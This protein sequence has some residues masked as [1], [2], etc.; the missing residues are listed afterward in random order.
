[1]RG[2]S[3]WSSS[4]YTS[5]CRYSRQVL[6][7]PAPQESLKI[8]GYVFAYTQQKLRLDETEIQLTNR[9]A[10]LL[11]R[12][13]DHRNQVLERSMVLLDLWGQDHFFNGRSLGVFVNRLRRYLRDDPQ[14]QILN[15]RSSGYKLIFRGRGDPSM[16]FSSVLLTSP[17]EY[18]VPNSGE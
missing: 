4:W 5:S 13:Y 18:D 17:D 3:I 16:I 10:E 15:V 2:R 14:V 1:M 12:L 9:E 6:L 8:G 7:A 11:K